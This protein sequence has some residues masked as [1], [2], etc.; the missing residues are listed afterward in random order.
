MITKNLFKRIITSVLL[1]LLLI[2]MY[3][4]NKVML[5]SL[6]FIS[7][8]SWL[9]FNKLF[10]KF[11]KKEKSKIYLLNF[12]TFIYL[13]FFVLLILKIG[14]SQKVYFFYAVIISISTDIGGYV[15]GKT[16]KGRK[17]TKISPNKTISGS[18]GSFVFSFSI[19]PFF[20]NY[21]ND[22]NLYQIILITFIISLTSQLGDL[23]LSYLKRKSKA[24]D[25]GNFLPGHGGILD[26][27]DGILFAAP[28]GVFLFILFL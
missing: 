1:I 16:F 24:K 12:I 25:T 3:N 15:V 8:I 7:I 13:S 23:M 11:L 20:I 2:L 18:I 4:S 27:I 14:D 10:S 6:I 22:I 5:I 9:E 21:Y 28:V 26:R 19:I 17:L